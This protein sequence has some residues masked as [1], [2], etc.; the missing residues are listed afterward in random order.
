MSE[1]PEDDGPVES[2]DVSPKDGN[3]VTEWN[4]KIINK[5]L[6]ENSFTETVSTVIGMYDRRIDPSLI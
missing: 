2:P 1:G 5:K 4:M 3:T 6:N